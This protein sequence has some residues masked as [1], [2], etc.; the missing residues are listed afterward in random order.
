MLLYNYS[1]YS[2]RSLINPILDINLTSLPFSNS[3]PK[4]CS[5]SS[6]WLSPQLDVSFDFFIHGYLS[7]KWLRLIFSS[8]RGAINVSMSSIDLGVFSSIKT[9]TRV[10]KS[11][12]YIRDRYSRDCV[13]FWEGV[14]KLH[15]SCI[16]SVPRDIKSCCYT[17]FSLSNW[18]P[19]TLSIS[20]LI[21]Y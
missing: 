1:T 6:L 21:F 9:D 20:Y 13:M 4:H 15:A 8:M 7:Y 10:F 18:Y 3:C 11:S 16:I 12:E 19:N 17:Q 2:G 5:R 14:D